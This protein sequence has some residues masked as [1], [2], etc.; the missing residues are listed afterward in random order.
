MRLGQKLL[1]NLAVMLLSALFLLG[2]SGLHLTQEG[3]FRA[4]QRYYH[5]GPGTILED[6]TV[7]G[8]RY[9]YDTYEGLCSITAIAPKGP[10]WENGGHRYEFQAGR[11]PFYQFC[12]GTRADHT[13]FYFLCATDPR[14]ASA[15]LSDREDRRVMGS[16]TRNSPDAR[17][18][19]WFPS[20]G[21]ASDSCPHTGILRVYDAA[22][23][24]LDE[25][26]CNY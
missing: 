7:D 22:G 2:L 12:T 5:Y 3:A 26:V 6:F 13:R 17:L 20:E 24:L 14:I 10:F 4:A 19:F 21:N 18:F 11:P 15:T 8:T 25:K 23:A 9:F 16:F 1:R